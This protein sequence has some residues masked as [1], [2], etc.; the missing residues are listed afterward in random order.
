MTDIAAITKRLKAYIAEYRKFPTWNDRLNAVHDHDND[1]VHEVKV[2]DFTALLEEIER[3][4]AERDET[5][6]KLATTQVVIYQEFR[7]SELSA[8]IMRDPLRTGHWAGA[9]NTAKAFDR[10]ARRLKA[11]WKIIRAIDPTT[12]TPIPDQTKSEEP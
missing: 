6:S 9:E 5:R 1:V 4:V 3:L 12:I 10:I 11:Q 2:S 7:A 8:Q